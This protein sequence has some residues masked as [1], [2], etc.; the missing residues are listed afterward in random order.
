M[1]DGVFVLYDDLCMVPADGQG[2]DLFF[3]NISGINSPTALTNPKGLDG[4]GGTRANNLD[5]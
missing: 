2:T 3:Q 1:K 4:L 5:L